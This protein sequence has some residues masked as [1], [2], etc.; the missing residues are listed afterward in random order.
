L[1]PGDAVYEGLCGACG[2]DL[3]L[4]EASSQ[5]CRHTGRGLCCMAE[6]AEVEEFLAFFERVVGKA[7]AL[8][9]QW[10]WRVL[11]GE[12]FAAV[13]PT[14]IGKTCFGSAMALFLAVNGRKSYMLMPTSLLVTQTVENLRKYAT[15]AGAELG[16]NTGD[17][18]AVLYYTSNLSR[19]ERGRFMELLEGGA[20]SILVTTTSFLARRFELLRGRVFDFIFVDDVDA[21]L[22]AS[23][24]VERL[25]NLLGFVQ[26]GGRWSGRAKGCMMVSTATARRGRNTGLFRELLGFDVG[27]QSGVLRNVEDYCTTAEEPETVAGILSRMGGGALLFARGM[28]EAEELHS[29]LTERFRAGLVTASQK[30]D[31][32]RF[33]EG[34]LDYLI[35]TSHYYGALVRGIDLPERVRYVVFVGAPALRLKVEDVESLSPRMLR[36]LAMVFRGVP[37]VG[38]F[39]GELHRVEKN[40][41]LQSR[42]RQAVAEAMA[43]GSSSQ[44]DVVVRR[45][46][47]V[48]PD[49]RTYIQGS[50]RASR[51]LAGGLT[52]GA[53]FLLE[54]DRELLEA[55]VR[56]AGYRDISFRRLEEAEFGRL[57]AEIDESRERC[58][59][60]NAGGETA[61][62]IVESPTK[63]RMISRFFGK[64]SMRVV[65]AGR[66]SIIAYEVLTPEM[67]LLVT[68]CLG[69]VTDLVAYT[70]FHGVLV[71]QGFVPVYSTVRRCRKCGYQFS[72]EAEGCPRCGEEEV[73]DAYERIEALRRLAKEAGRVIIGTDPDSEGEKIAWDLA[74]L[75]AG[76]GEVS[77]A[78]FHEV[79]RRAVEKALQNPR[80]LD[81]RLVSAQMVRR[82]EDRWIGFCLSQRLW[83]VF[84]KRNLSAGRAQT[85]LLGWIIQR[86]EQSRERVTVGVVRELGLRLEGLEQQEAELFIVL[87]SERR[88]ERTPLP[89]Y[90]TDT[91]LRD[92]N[93]LLRLDA[94]EAMRLAQELFESGL[95]TYHRTDSTRVSDAGMRVAEEFLGED[96][97]RRRWQAE[98]AHECI[99]PTR[100]VP[101]EELQ[102][103]IEEGVVHAEAR[104]GRHMRL[105]EMIF[106]RFMASMCRDFKVREAAYR[107][108]WKG[109][110][111]EEVRVLEAEGRAHELY[112]W[113]AQ[114]KPPLPTGRVR[115]SAE[116]RRVPRVLPLS[117]AEAVQLMKEKGIGRPSTYAVLLERLLMRGYVA[118]KG[119]RL[120]PTRLGRSVYEYLASNY[121]SL[122][123]EERTRMLMR[124]M[125]EIERG[126]AEYGRVV[127]EMYREIERWGLGDSKG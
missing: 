115:V 9:R 21:V 106:R 96:F 67:V 59:R 28:E 33:R 90:T 82:I 73:D 100:A 3:S 49:V 39:A 26:E 51:M 113:A 34:E 94:G 117:Q 116:L 53:S 15:K 58:R 38:R 79:T 111:A 37:E 125:D 7:R 40:R 112:P 24:N 17:E 92:A 64:P 10:A 19:A 124:V 45:G 99:R 20:G 41:K 109:G 52:K 104:S 65:R 46:E 68:A 127:E 86:A 77:R 8:Q 13:A 44:R 98:G 121:R 72:W 123:S 83:E 76:C 55:F 102:R 108:S 2:G 114:V 87:V 78:E 71:E 18:P 42:L 1:M 27:T 48:F 12:S 84:G 31:F 101:A 74:N 56:R 25:L 35:G 119:G 54:K 5:R 14:G 66:G 70:G 63:A 93:A 80:A 11:R 118:V 6:D 126:E 43:Q 103:L 36:V 122:I 29:L 62:L 105:Y 107:I 22:K 69:H 75:L 60:G 30:R 4:A 50:G 89:P 88:E 23:R 57:A 85:P 47:V 110:S 120:V 61:L 91:L 81:E 97:Q 95:I 32:A 16:F